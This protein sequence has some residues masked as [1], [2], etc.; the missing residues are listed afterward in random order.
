[1]NHNT[2]LVTGCAGF[3]GNSLIRLLLSK[4]YNVVGLDNFHKMSSGAML[5]VIHDTNFTFYEGDVRNEYLLENI[6][7]KHNITQ[8]VHLAAI[9][10]APSCKKNVYESYSVNVVGAQILNSLAD[11]HI[12][13]VFASTGSVYGSVKDKMCTENTLCNPQSEYGQQKLEAEEI[14]SMERDNTIVLRFA[15]GFG[16]DTPQTRVNLLVNDLV[17][18]AINNKSITI[19]EADAWRTFIHVSDM[20]EAILFFLQEGMNFSDRVYNVGCESLNWTKRQLANYIGE[21]TSC[22][23][24]FKDFDKDPDSRDYQVDYS[25]IHDKG[26]SPSKTMEQGIDDLIKAVPIMKIRHSYE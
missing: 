13:I 17:Y 8:I 22:V 11:S 20:S 9:V 2:V 3:V 10:G 14:L 25:R 5:E 1:M 21:K 24:T 4:K 15:T 26:W 6:L 23:V 12:P 16:V 7:R 18:Q 19:F